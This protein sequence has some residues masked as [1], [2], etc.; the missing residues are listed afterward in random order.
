MK[1]KP[2]YIIDSKQRCKAFG[3]NPDTPPQFTTFLSDEELEMKKR[4][5]EE[6]LTVIKGFIH[7]LL[8]FVE[9][10]PLLILIT[11]EKGYILE[12]A[13]DEAIKTIVNQSGIKVSLG[14]VEHEA[15]TNSIN[16]A[17]DLLQ[18]IGI[19]G[20]EHY[21]NFLDK[22][23]CYTVPFQYLDD[24]QVLGTITIMT[25][26]EQ[27]NP[28]LL[29]LLSTVVDSIER[30]LLLKKKNHK[31][32]VLNQVVIDTTRNGIIITDKNGIVTEFNNYAEQMTGDLKQDVLHTLYSQFKYREII[33]QVISS[34]KEFSDLEFIFE[35]PNGEA[36]ICSAEAFPIRDEDQLL[37]GGFIQFRDITERTKA[38][39]KINYLA[40][41]DELTALP[42]RRFF[43]QY[44]EETL[45][46]SASSR[47]K[48]AVMF[49]DL[50]RF[51]VINDNLGHRR[52]DIVLT[53]VA[54]RIKRV[55][56]KDDMVAR[57]G[58]DEFTILIQKMNGMSEANEIA[59]QLLKVFES[60]F[61][62]DGYD[63]FVTASIG[64]A[65]YPDH[66][67]NAET[68]MRHADIAMYRAKEQGKNN[69][70]VYKS[71]KSEGLNQL[72]LEN[73][74]RK[75]L[76][77]NEFEL[78]YQPQM[79]I[80]TGQIF[81]AEALLRWNHPKIGYIPPNVFIP[82]AEELGLIVS[83]G[84]WVVEEACRELA[85]WRQS[86]PE[87][88]VAV[89]LSARQFLK[90]NLVA[91]IYEIMQKTNTPA[92]CLELEITES[93]TMDVEHA[94]E[95][96]GQLKSLGVKVSIDDFGTGYSNL[97]YLKKFSVDSLKIDQSFI[98]DIVVD[99]N[100]ADIVATIIAMADRLGIGVIA[101]G[102]ETEEQLNFLIQHGCDSAQGY[103]FYRPLPA[104]EFR[105][106]L[107]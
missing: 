26:V 20:K 49:L 99:D 73:S 46:C 28:F 89:N 70:V 16:L 71:I 47:S 34:E 29:P 11:D 22:S 106:V 91:R 18:P 93:M 60:P 56:S 63:L 79:N 4:Q 90:Q 2:Q 76:Q 10:F 98:R 83:I 30:E 44:L 94:S 39:K 45:I 14:F 19:I 105:A 50:D 31:L 81:G 32:H 101:E 23:A 67:I 85:K 100:D 97:Y 82:V 9:G 55:V 1:V 35:R 92:H 42:N 25:S 88:R 77:N 58:G 57:L 41:H 43:Q 59:E 78:H 7:K 12:M 6:I 64:I 51:K 62:L 27:H 65:I 53:K 84:E 13:G 86:L 37:L 66:G 80:K 74:L 68:L 72:T 103:F 48:F 5:Y 102:V 8:G 21:Y 107:R 96:I 69:Y 17:L 95:I 40:F 24:G 15:G 54:R 87:L 33:K 104:E 38:E 3:L 75:A 52:G 61:Q 36:V